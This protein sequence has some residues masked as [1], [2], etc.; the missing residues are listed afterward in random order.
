[1]AGA[2]SGPGGSSAPSVLPLSF[3]SLLESLM[4]MDPADMNMSLLSPFNCQAKVK[5][6]FPVWLEA[7]SNN[8]DST[9]SISLRTCKQF[10]CQNKLCSDKLCAVYRFSFRGCRSLIL[11]PNRVFTIMSFQYNAIHQQGDL[12][13]SGK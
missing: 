8:L 7:A 1:M 10:E 12:S 4:I 2:L 3:D 9:T 6:F 13:Y 11:L 5:F